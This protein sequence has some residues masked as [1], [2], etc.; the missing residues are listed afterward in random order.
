MP[1]LVAMSAGSMV[2][3]LTARIFTLIGLLSYGVYVIH[4]PLAGIAEIV[5]ARLGYHPPGFVTVLG[6]GAAA[7]LLAWLAD[8]FYDGPLR[9]WMTA[10]VMRAKAE[11]VHL[12]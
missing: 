9:K 6:V 8:K 5:F 1:L 3:G 2:H 7:A 4:V 12:S 10:R 11:T